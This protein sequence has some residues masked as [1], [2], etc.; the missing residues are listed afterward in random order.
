MAIPNY[1]EEVKAAIVKYAD[2]FAHAHMDGD[3]RRHEFI[4]LL[5]MDLRAIDL[6]VAM[7]GKRGDPNNPSMDAI[8]I[9]CTAAESDGRT[10][11]QRPCVVVDVIA[12]AGAKPPYTAQ[13]PAPHAAW[14]VYKTK[15]EGSGAHVVPAIQTDPP[16]PPAQ[17]SFPY[18]DEQVAVRRYQDRVKAAYRAV[19][20]AFPDPLDEDA[21]RHFTR[22]GFSCHEM[23][24]PDAAAK[25]IKELRE[26]LGAPP[27]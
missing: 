20:R 9:L 7:N 5:A 16:A 26:E 22:Y 17:P 12:R 6:R 3:P 2:A 11:D 10:P 1:L 15:V 14:D 18:P 19:G 23:P 21:F 13:N 4:R 27:E 24:E 8:N 25:H